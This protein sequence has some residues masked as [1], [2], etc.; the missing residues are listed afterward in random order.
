MH[1]E[2]CARRPARVKSRA[3][4]RK[5]V[6]VSVLACFSLATLSWTQNK[7]SSLDSRGTI[8]EEN[9]YT[10][11]ALGMTINLPGDW[12]LL[13]LTTE[14][15]TDSSCT[16][17]LCGSP[18]I[19][20][21][22][23]SKPGENPSYRLYLSGW[24]LSGQYLNRNRYPLK[25]FAGIMMEGSLGQTD[26]VP[27]GERTAIEFGGRPAFRLLLARPEETTARVVGYV[28]ESNGYVFLLV[29][30]TPTN[31]RALQAAVEGMKL[32]APGH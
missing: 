28:S 10:N 20:A 9:T 26:L 30:A 3:M 7:Q 25:W 29:G 12:R 11:P 1:F 22:L 23:E 31:P 21:V 8:S 5:W 17:P 15:P 27:I 14:S 13:Q 2:V 32:S 18:D 6:F 4:R 19:N 16:G 24:K